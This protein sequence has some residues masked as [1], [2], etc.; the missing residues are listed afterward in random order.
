MTKGMIFDIEEFAVYDGPGIRQVVFL[1]GCPLQCSWCHNPEGKLH[2]RE[3]MVQRS[4]CI[5]C[6]ACERVCKNETCI[7]CGACVERCPL[8][9]RKIV[10]ESMDAEALAD[11]IRKSNAY[12]QSYGGG[13]TFSGGEPLAQP[14]FLLETLARLD[15]IHC[16]IETS[17]YCSGEVFSAVVE[18]LDYVIMDLKV[19]DPKKHK[20]YVGVDNGGILENF[21]YLAHGKKPFVIR[22][23]LI[24]G[25]ND[26]ER[27]Y[28]QTAQLLAGAQAMER[29]ELLPYHKA[30]GAKYEMVN[31]QY[32]P[33]FDPDAE[34][35]I[36]Q[37]IFSEYG[38]R[39]VVL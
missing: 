32:T 17:G 14:E 29:V 22:I 39:S 30:A 6:G 1:K 36:R 31:R 16:A 10:G 19:I 2:R 13:V 25:V 8:H 21:Q 7:A 38:I 4:A 37:E 24:P 18:R 35:C 3:L 27:N 23:P 34:V 28:R 5:S 15:G 20:K 26:D 12:Y 11:R 33:D 9:L